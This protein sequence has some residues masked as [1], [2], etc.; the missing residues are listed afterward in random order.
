MQLD[1]DSLTQVEHTNWKWPTDSKIW[2][3]FLPNLTKN[4]ITL[5]IPIDLSLFMPNSENSAI[6]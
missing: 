1:Y 5:K 4:A 6:L 2:D 3:R